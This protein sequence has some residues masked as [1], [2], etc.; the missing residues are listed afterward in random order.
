VV[1]CACNLSAA[2]E[3]WE[4]EAGECLENAA[5]NEESGSNEE[6]GED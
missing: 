3:R 4:T 1:E 5:V 2:V 6:E